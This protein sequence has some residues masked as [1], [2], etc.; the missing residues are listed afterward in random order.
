MHWCGWALSL[1]KVWPFVD[2]AVSVFGD[3]LDGPRSL[4]SA[5]WALLMSSTHF[6]RSRASNRSCPPIRYPDQHI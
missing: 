5:P 6:A 4:D 1:E 3:Y 2:A